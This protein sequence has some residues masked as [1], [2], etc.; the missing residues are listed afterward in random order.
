MKFKFLT[1]PK[2]PKFP[3]FPRLKIKTIKKIVSAPVHHKVATAV[4]ISFIAFITFAM[5]Y[6][7]HLL[8]GMKST[9]E[10]TITDILPSIAPVDP[11]PTIISPSETGTRKNVL[12]T[13]DYSSPHY[14][15]PSVSSTP[16]PTLPPLPTFAPVQN[17]ITTSTGNYPS[18][19]SGNSN[20]TTDAGVP[21]SWYSDVYPNPP[22][23]TNTGSVQMIVT[24]RD[25]KVT[26]T[27]V[28]D[29]INIS[30]I[31][32]DPNTQING[33]NLPYSLTATSGQASFYVTSQISGSVT[34]LVQ[35]TTKSFT[36][37]DINNH[38]PAITFNSTTPSLSGNSNCTTA[39]GVPNAWYSDVYPASPVSASTGSTVTFTVNI[40]DCNK[41]T[42]SAADNLTFSQTSNDSTLKV[43]G[44][45][46]P[47]SLQAQNG[48]ATFTLS[49][50]NAGTDTFSIKDTTG[51]FTITDTNNHN[52]SV[53]FTSSSTTT[54][55]STPVP[56]IINAVNTPSPNPSPTPSSN[57]SPNPTAAP[58]QT[59]SN[60]PAPDPTPTQQSNTP[61]PI[62]T[63]VPTRP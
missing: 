22:V 51:S 33:N 58:T 50:Q 47:V 2:F 53:V 46:P 28:N 4:T 9:A 26:T 31:N 30:L 35:D 23:S 21:N 48:Q 7:G 62:P 37:T 5:W 11:S 20:C 63:A 34:L 40:R 44:A 10:N 43:N 14:N 60:S 1:L 13:S 42:V 6:R 25:C 15:I 57:P 27:P 36:V 59:P 45:V 12:G 56:T 24:L 61:T 32:G 52:P 29:T 19:N 16:Y 54:P 17:T 8:A 3:H 55:T 38:N 41:N 39:A 18:T 49:S